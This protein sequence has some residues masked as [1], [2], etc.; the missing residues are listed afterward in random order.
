MPGHLRWGL[1]CGDDWGTLEAM[2]ACRQL[3]LG[4][5]NHG[6]QVSEERRETEAVA[7]QVCVL[8]KGSPGPGNW[9][10]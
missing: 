6:L 7:N 1:I 5:A 2:V 8:G 9:N 10:L 3:G 4:Y